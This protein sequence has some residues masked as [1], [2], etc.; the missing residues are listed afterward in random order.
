MDAQSFRG[1]VVSSNHVVQLF[2]T[3]LSRAQ[4]IAAFVAEG[5]AAGQRCI[6][7]VRPETASAVE[8][9]LQTLGVA[10][11]DAIA[12]GRLIVND[13]HETLRRI[14][15]NGTPERALFTHVME[16]AVRALAGPQ[17]LRACGEMVDILAQRGDLKGSIAL[18]AMWC[19]LAAQTP[20]VLLCAYSSVHFVSTA[21]HPA[22]IDICEL[23]S[24]IHRD[25]QDPLGNWLLTAAHN[26][27]G[28][29]STLQH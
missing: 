21:T 2:D 5:L 13:A 1:Q 14:S 6:V 9:Q 12:G 27:G 26:R 24:H 11:P 4:N 28:A 15:R 8:E 3:D 20:M 7:V 18:E 23:H 22:L 17:G 16:P 25:A 29:R 19:E 10:V